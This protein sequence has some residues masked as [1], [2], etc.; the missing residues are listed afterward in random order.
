MQIAARLTPIPNEP[1]LLLM[2]MT[3]APANSD[4]VSL[5]IWVETRIQ[6]HTLAHAT[7]ELADAVGRPIRQSRV[8]EWRDG[9]YAPPPDVVHY[10]MPVVIERALQLALGEPLGTYSDEQ[11]DHL[12]AWLTITEPSRE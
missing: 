10:M 2:L 7:H 12:A 8:Y 4:L 5:W 6:G 1:P 11:L 9:K 3:D